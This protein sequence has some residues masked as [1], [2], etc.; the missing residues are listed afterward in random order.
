MRALFRAAQQVS[1][2]KFLELKVGVVLSSEPGWQNECFVSTVTSSGVLLSGEVT[3]VC[4]LEEVFCLCY[5][6]VHLVSVSIS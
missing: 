3:R 1:V 4:E 2:F 5:L 6:R